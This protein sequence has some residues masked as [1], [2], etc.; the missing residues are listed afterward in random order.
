MGWPL[1]IRTESRAI[2]AQEHGVGDAGF[3]EALGAQH[4]AV[5]R[6]AGP[7]VGAGIVAAVR[8][9]VVEAELQPAPDD[10]GLAERDERRVHAKPGALDAGARREVGET[11]ERG[12]E[13][14]PAVGIAR[15]SRAR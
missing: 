7:S 1:R 3:A 12:D 11:L 2:L 8:Q 6:A 13:L 4:A 14:R 15:N 9:A 5:A 10:V